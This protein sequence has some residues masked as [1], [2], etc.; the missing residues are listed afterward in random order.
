MKGIIIS[1]Q[2]KWEE[3]LL[4]LFS[5]FSPEIIDFNNFD[6]KKLG[7]ADFI[8]L[9]GGPIH[10]SNEED[11]QEEKEF[12]KETNKP[13]LGIC[14]GLEI[15]GVTFGSRLLKLEKSRKGFFGFDFFGEKGKLYFSHE[16]FIKDVPKHYIVRRKRK[17]IIEL[18]QHKTK[19]FIGIQGH[20]E[21]SGKYGE[22][23]RDVFIKKFVL[24]PYNNP[25]G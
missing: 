23:I 7:D 13:I 14:L 25:R 18:M 5:E 15:L 1:H 4:N 19:P 17:N 3:D 10:I 21:K 16:W 8:V 24:T 9:S 20:P 12:L 6:E 2:S 11:L 22:K